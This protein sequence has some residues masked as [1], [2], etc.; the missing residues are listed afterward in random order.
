[1]SYEDKA[2]T[3]AIGMNAGISKF[4]FSK[5]IS[6]AEFFP[7]LGAK[8]MSPNVPIAAAMSSSEIGRFVAGERT[9][10]VSALATTL[11][12]SDSEHSMRSTSGEP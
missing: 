11:R 7:D 2:S 6:G 1:M 12:P 8:G 3:S 9:L 10:F 4:S 5:L